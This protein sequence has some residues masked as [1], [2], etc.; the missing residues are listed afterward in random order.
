MTFERK[1]PQF[2]VISFHPTF[3]F[4]SA[5]LAFFSVV[6]LLSL[7]A[8]L[9][10]LWIVC[11]SFGI[12]ILTARETEARS[13]NA[14]TFFISHRRLVSGISFPFIDHAIAAVVCSLTSGHN[15]VNQAEINLSGIIIRFLTD[16]ECEVAGIEVITV[17]RS[18][19]FWDVDCQIRGS[20]MGGNR[21]TFS[22]LVWV[23]SRLWVCLDSS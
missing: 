20:A 10:C 13:N 15:V 2:S 21:M 5:R 16:F 14:R 17:E 8:L 3:F 1:V 22:A 11:S 19:D 12:S 18:L 7:P 9:W 23:E 4:P 6:H